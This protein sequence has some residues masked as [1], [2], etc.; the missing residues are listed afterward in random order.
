[1][2]QKL[3]LLLSSCNKAPNVVDPYSEQFSVSG[4]TIYLNCLTFGY[5]ILH[6]SESTNPSQGIYKGID[7]HSACS[8]TLYSLKSCNWLTYMLVLLYLS[9]LSKKQATCRKNPCNNIPQTDEHLCT[10]GHCY[11]QENS[12]LIWKR[13]LSDLYTYSLQGA[14]TFQTEIKKLP[15]LF[16]VN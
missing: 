9:P 2:Y 1:M 3:A 5:N 4:V 6:S 15:L 16:N 7:G 14:S 10:A 8:V 12:N 11:K 13:G